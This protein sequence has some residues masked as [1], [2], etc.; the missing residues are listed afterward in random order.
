MA[1]FLNRMAARALGSVAMAQPVV[2]AMFTPGFGLVQ[3]VVP[4]DA[5]LVG[6]VSEVAV[7]ADP[8]TPTTLEPARDA[9]LPREWRP[10]DSRLAVGD[11]SA[12]PP[13]RSL[14]EEEKASPAI[15]ARRLSPAT[16]ATQAAQLALPPVSVSAIPDLQGDQAET[17][18]PDR[19]VVAN[20]SDEK[21]TDADLRTKVAPLIAPEVMSARRPHTHPFLSGPGSTSRDRGSATR[22][23]QGASASPGPPV[24]RVTI[25][26]IDVRAQFPAPAPSP[27]PARR[28]R[29]AALTL[30]DYLKQRSEGKR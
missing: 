29:P 13:P 1:N 6:H 24:V 5:G 30:E 21:V 12:V 28:A 2:P 11:A 19:V 10:S 23:D 25:G 22:R 27:V 17:F 9:T 14:S 8:A 3:S 18:T 15:H 20:K 7:V 4:R 16:A 26:R